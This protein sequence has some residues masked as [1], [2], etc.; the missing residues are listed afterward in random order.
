MTPER[1]DVLRR[2]REASDLVDERP[3]PSARA[4]ILAAAG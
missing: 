4:A 2:Y 1:D 3:S